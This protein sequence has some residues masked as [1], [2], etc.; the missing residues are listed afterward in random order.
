MV[1]ILGLYVLRQYDLADT[2]E[3]REGEEGDQWTRFTSFHDWDLVVVNGDNRG[4]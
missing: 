3:Q 1:G 2:N 4:D